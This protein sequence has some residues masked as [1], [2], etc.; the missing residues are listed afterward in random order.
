[1]KKFLTIL[2]LILIANTIYSQVFNNGQTLKPMQFSAGVE[3]GFLVNG[4]SEFITFLNGGFGV[5][6][7]V[8]LSVK[9]GILGPIDYFGADAEF[10]LGNRM[11]VVA[12]FHQFGDFGLDGAWNVSFPIRRDIRIS[13]GIDLDINFYQDKNQ[14]LLWLPVSL[15]VGIKKNMSFIFESEIGLNDPAYN[16]FGGG[17]IFYFL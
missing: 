14:I 2:A 11:S 5:T 15:E 4:S 7:G 10:A 9:V 12:G 1:M 17:V 13:S 6:K 16:F 3:P 8:D